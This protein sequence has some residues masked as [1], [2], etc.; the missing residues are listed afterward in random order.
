M[1]AY[2]A[3]REAEARRLLEE[4]DNGAT[5]NDAIHLHHDLQADALSGD[6]MRRGVPEDTSE[7]VLTAA[8]AHSRRCLLDHP[9]PEHRYVLE[10]VHAVLNGTY[11][12]PPT[13]ATTTKLSQSIHDD[14]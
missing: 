8:L 13:P 7:E 10:Q 9:H 12:P 6:V 14:C 11:V 2:I 5:E 1:N 3:Q 4:A